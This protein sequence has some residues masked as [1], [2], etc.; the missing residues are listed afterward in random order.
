MKKK[1]YILADA[2]LLA[3][4]GQIILIGGAKAKYRYADE[5]SKVS[6]I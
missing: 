5:P 2:C 6:F 3:L 1:I 4:G